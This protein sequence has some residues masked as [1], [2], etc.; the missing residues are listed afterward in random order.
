MSPCI[1]ELGGLSA[2]HYASCATREGAH[3]YPLHRIWSGCGGGEKN[4]SSCQEVDPYSSSMQLKHY[5]N[6]AVPSAR[7]LKYSI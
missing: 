1:I 2:S 7:E 5:I 3:Q 4:I 6:R